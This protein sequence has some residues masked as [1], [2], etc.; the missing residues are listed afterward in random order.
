MEKV[1]IQMIVD[2][3]DSNTATVVMSYAAKILRNY[4]ED[5]AVKRSGCREG[6]PPARGSFSKTGPGSTLT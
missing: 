1:A 6:H 4:N 2:G 3:T 5:L